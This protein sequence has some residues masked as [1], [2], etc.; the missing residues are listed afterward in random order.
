MD[1]LGE[2][3]LRRILLEEAIDLTARL[4]GNAAL[5]QRAL[6]TLPTTINPK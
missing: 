2:L 3:N 5:I 6:S 4:G 1:K